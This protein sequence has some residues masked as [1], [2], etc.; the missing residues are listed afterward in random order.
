[1]SICSIFSGVFTDKVDR[2]KFLTVGSI[3]WSAL[4]LS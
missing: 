3:I 4:T 2:V 1:L